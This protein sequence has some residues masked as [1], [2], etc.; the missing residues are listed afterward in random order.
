MA[1]VIYALHFDNGRPGDGALD[2][3]RNDPLR[4]TIHS[5]ERS[6]SSPL[7]LSYECCATFRKAHSTT[8]STSAFGF[9]LDV[10][11]AVNHVAVSESLC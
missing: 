1:I 11:D 3:P 6:T 10:S 5:E 7:P 2:L 9:V 8:L 4:G